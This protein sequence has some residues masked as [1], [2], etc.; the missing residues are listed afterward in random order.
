MRT[1]VQEDPIPIYADDPPGHI[2][3]SFQ[4]YLRPKATLLRAHESVWHPPT[5]IFET[6]DGYVVRVELAGMR[7]EEIHVR[8]DSG[9]LTIGGNR[10][11]R[12]PERKVR[13]GQMEVKFGTFEVRLRLSQNVDLERVQASYR[14]GFLETR[15][16]KVE[17]PKK[18]VT[19][20]R[21]EI[22]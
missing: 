16:P 20:V 1:S 18:H 19:Q 14:N 2:P 9:V 4:V 11:D 7:K 13:Y 10:E 22:G 8:I 5:D 21:I 6:E 15:L 3:S 17:E 12:S